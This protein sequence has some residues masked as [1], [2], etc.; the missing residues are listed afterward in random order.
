MRKTDRKS[1]RA[2]TGFSPAAACTL[3]DAQKFFAVA[4]QRVARR[5]G[6]ATPR[7]AVCKPVDRGGLRF[8]S[9]EWLGMAG[10]FAVFAA[11]RGK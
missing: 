10:H 4:L 3:P 11:A 2:I 6:R 5:R 9:E 8:S 7:A 1:S